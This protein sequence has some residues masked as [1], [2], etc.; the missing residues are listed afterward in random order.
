MIACFILT[1]YCFQVDALSSAKF[2]SV[3]AQEQ[4]VEEAERFDILRVSP[5]E[6]TSAL[7][8]G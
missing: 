4:M 2:S 3:K 1:P 8:V 6:A 5:V 7:P